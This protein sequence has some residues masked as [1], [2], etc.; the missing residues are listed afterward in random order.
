MREPCCDAMYE[1]PLY[2]FKVP[3]SGEHIRVLFCHECR[4]Q[5]EVEVPKLKALVKIP[6][7]RKE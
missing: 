6:F 7:S 5:R 1:R 4:R 3:F 2:S